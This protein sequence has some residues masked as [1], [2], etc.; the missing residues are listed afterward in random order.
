MLRKTFT[1]ALLLGLAAWVGRY[2]TAWAQVGGTT[3]TEH[4]LVQPSARRMQT[5]SAVLPSTERTQRGSRLGGELQRLQQHSSSQTARTAATSRAALPS[6]FPRLRFSPDASSVLVRITAQDVNALL[7]KLLSRGFVVTASYPDLHFVE[8][9]LPVSQ[10]SGNEGVVGLGANGLLG[11][12]PG[13]KPRLHGGRVTSQADYTLEAARARATKPLNLTGTGVRVGVMSDS[14]NA[15]QGAAADITSG[16][17]PAAGVQVLQDLTAKDDGTDEGR[18]MCQLVNDLAPG[19]ALAFSSVF[20]GEGNFAQQI[21]DLADPTK[22]NCKIL[23]DDIAYYSEP[24]FQDGVIA[25]AINQVVAQRGV[26][27]FSAAGN[28]GDQSYENNTPQFVQATIGT[29]AAA[30]LNFDVS[31]KTTDVTQ[32]VTLANGR[33]FHPV[34]EWS[35]PFYTT[36][37]VKTD[38]DMYLIAVKNGIAGDT[39]AAST[40]DNIANQTPVENT[41]DFTNDTRTSGTTTFDLVIVRY[42][43][44]A[45][46]ARIKYVDYGTIDYSSTTAPEWQT[47]SPTLVGH[48]AAAGA[49]AV[50]AVN[51]A[52]QRVAEYYTSKGGAIPFLFGPTGTP[53]NPVQTRQK[54]DIASVDGTDT[55]FFGSDN[56]AS[57]DTEGNGFPNFYG[58][59]A[60]A[61]HAAAAA[62]LLRQAEPT[63]T[64]TQVYARLVG[65]ARL[66]GTSATD[67]LTG[68]GLLDA[69]TAIYGQPTVAIPPLAEG[70]EQG[71]LPVNWRVNSTGAG[72]VQV[73][74]TL[75]PATGTYHLVLDAPYAG[76]NN[77]GSLNEAIWYLQ[78]IGG[79]SLQLT[80][81]ERKLAGETD[82][83][84]PVSFTGSSNTDGV[85]LSVDGGV[86]W[87]RVAD[88]TS[89]NATTTYQTKTIDLTSFAATNGLTLGADVR[90]K[91]QQYSAASTSTAIAA[92]RGRLFDDI[93]IEAFANSLVVEAWPNPLP[94]GTSLNLRLPP[95]TGSASLRVIDAIGRVVWQEQVQQAGALVRTL[96]LAVAPG[97]YSVLYQQS[98]SKVVGKHIAIE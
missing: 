26:A 67:P 10:L 37:G 61:P 79:S 27:Y 82:E 38:L 15:L 20:Y 65:S 11:V 19:A 29:A 28:E 53:L 54:P 21:I 35:D 13:W 46:P 97:I 70:L 90:L 85:A 77:G 95:Y 83:V 72:R 47:H 48:A 22:G 17:L 96:S 12:L 76:Y 89:T 84:M 1:R 94:K 64:P 43:S 86:T 25:Q 8:G 41:I 33:E 6:S 78:G 81:S 50:A 71:A 63:L 58:T 44:T 30:R 69:F 87:Y 5:Q 74:T 34:L 56:L 51:Y 16:D 73:L 40:D 98:G 9:M 59:S 52:E 42:G 93:I 60:A 2:Q 68:P 14:F 62:A 7:P 23:T 66:I 75:M 18:A 36:N 80:F 55:S 92:Q 49:Q 24:F 4:H 31:G 57:S 88:L 45:V 32:R 3:A 39:I 91:F